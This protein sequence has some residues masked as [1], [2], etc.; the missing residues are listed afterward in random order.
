[1][2]TYE[3]VCNHIHVYAFI[4]LTIYRHVSNDYVCCPRMGSYSPV[5]PDFVAN[6]GCTTIKYNWF[7]TI[8]TPPRGIIL[9]PHSPCFVSAQPPRVNTNQKSPVLCVHSKANLYLIGTTCDAV[10]RS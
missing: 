10:L 6:M 7:A 9:R 4:R 2:Y 1:M 8:L 3:Y 5:V